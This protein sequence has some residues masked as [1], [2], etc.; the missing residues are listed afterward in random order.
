[1]N[2]RILASGS[3][4]NAAV[5]EHGGTKI[6]LDA[7]LSKKQM[8]LLLNGESIQAVL[9]SHAHTDHASGVPAMAK[10]FN[11]PVY[12]SDGTDKMIRWKEYKPDLEI[13]AAGKEITIGRISII[14]FTIKHDCIEPLGFSF[15]A[16]GRRIT[17]AVDLAYVSEEIGELMHQ[18]D[19]SVLES[20]F[21]TESLR[22]APY[23]HETRLR[24]SQSHLSNEKAAEFL[25]A[26]P[27][28]EGQQ[29]VLAHL[30][31][32]TNSPANARLESQEALGDSPLGLHISSEILGKVL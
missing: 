2:I 25:K 21:V 7:G 30:S 31:T 22:C 16:D 9:C 27:W 26:N 19:V 14:P 18:S 24:I 13:I 11:C 23:P 17:V 10:L 5:I 1:M 32:N 29:M 8:L 28:K 4:G 6:L 20:N 15:A 12:T 3:S